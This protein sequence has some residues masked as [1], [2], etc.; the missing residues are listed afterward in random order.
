MP[1]IVWED[2]RRVIRFMRYQCRLPGWTEAIE[3]KFP[4]T[5]NARRDKLESS[6][7]KL[8]GYRHGIILAD[9]FYEHVLYHNLEQRPLGAGEAEE[10][11]VLEFKPRGIGTM[12]W[13][14][15]GT[16]H[17]SII[18]A[19]D[20]RTRGAGM[21]GETAVGGVGIIAAI[22]RPGARATAVGTA[23]GQS[24]RAVPR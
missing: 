15:S 6:W 9:A 10:D 18:G 17:R 13:P 5:Y 11:V 21:A 24:G 23:A 4:G 12:A 20:R 22:V 8:F 14:A 1:V 7:A 19:T 16:H 2:G 3:R